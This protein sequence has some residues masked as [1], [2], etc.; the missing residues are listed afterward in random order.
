MIEPGRLR[1]LAGAAEDAWLNGLADEAE[2]EGT[3]GTVS[4]EEM[5]AILRDEQP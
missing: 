2:G 4:L 1:R 3:E 5:A